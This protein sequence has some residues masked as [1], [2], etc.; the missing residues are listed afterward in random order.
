MRKGSALVSLENSSMH[1][2]SAVAA[3]LLAIQLLAASQ[4]MLVHSSLAGV[5]GFLIQSLCQM[6]HNRVGCRTF[7]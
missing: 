4:I 2:A 1:I 3:G 5:F 7:V 6:Y